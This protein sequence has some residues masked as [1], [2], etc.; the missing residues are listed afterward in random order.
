MHDEKALKQKALGEFR[1]LPT[2]LGKCCHHDFLPR[3]LTFTAQQ[4]AKLAEAQQSIEMMKERLRALEDK[5]DAVTM[6]RGRVALQ[7]A[8]CPI[9]CLIDTHY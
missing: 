1:A 8:V 7:Y 5:H 2:K 9:A 4:E 3:S 6:E